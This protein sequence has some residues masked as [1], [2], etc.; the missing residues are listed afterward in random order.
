MNVR[1]F[2]SYNFDFVGLCDGELSKSDCSMNVNISDFTGR[3][4]MIDLLR[5]LNIGHG[6]CIKIP[7]HGICQKLLVIEP[8]IAFLII[9]T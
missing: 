9:N 4:L 8:C 6:G 2:S 3:S 7:M 1:Y 5:F